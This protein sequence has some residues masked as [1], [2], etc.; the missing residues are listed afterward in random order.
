[1]K[2]ADYL[3]NNLRLKEISLLVFFPIYCQINRN[4]FEI[5]VETTYGLNQYYL[6]FGRSLVRKCFGFHLNSQGA[7]EMKDLPVSIVF[8]M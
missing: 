6:K 4:Q 5:V 7:D 8:Q 1:M 3:N 2:I